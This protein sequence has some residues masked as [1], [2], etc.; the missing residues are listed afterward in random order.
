MS[1]SSSFNLHFGN[2]QPINQEANMQEMYRKGATGNSSTEKMDELISEGEE[3]IK[4]VVSDFEQKIRQGE[5][6]LKQLASKV[7]Q[8]LHENPWPIVAGVAAGC[9]LIGFLAGNSRKN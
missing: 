3:K 7:D 8:Q 4:G 6:Q 2:L 9:L 5:Q 1:F